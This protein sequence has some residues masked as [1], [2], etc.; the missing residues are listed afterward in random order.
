MMKA[1]GGR[2]I[3][4]GFGQGDVT[5]P[6]SASGLEG[7]VDVLAGDGTLVFCGIRMGI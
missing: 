3:L 1:L 6:S 2:G 7:E 5:L 4:A